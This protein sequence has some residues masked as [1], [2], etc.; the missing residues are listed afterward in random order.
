[1]PISISVDAPTSAEIAALQAA[2]NGLA[3]NSV[4]PGPTPTPTPTPTPVDYFPADPGSAP[5]PSPD[6]SSSQILNGAVSGAPYLRSKNGAIYSW[7]LNASGTPVALPA[8][9][10]APTFVGYQLNIN[11]SP[12]TEATSPPIPQPISQMLTRNGGVYFA[13]QNGQGYG[14]APNDLTNGWS[15]TALPAEN[16]GGT[17]ALPAML[18]DP[19][20]STPAPGSTGVVHLVGPSQA[21]VAGGFVTLAAAVAGAKPGDTLQLDVG[22]VFEESVEITIPLEINGQGTVANPGTVTASFS[23]GA[24][25][26]GSTF[27][28]YA[29]GK[30]GLVPSVDCIF[31]GLEVR[32]FGLTDASAQGTAGIRPTGTAGCTVTIDNCYVHD[33]E[34]GLSS[35]ASL[36]D[37]VITDSLFENCGLGDG[38]THNIYVGT[39]NAVHVSLSGVTSIMPTA[40]P[41]TSGSFPRATG[42]AYGG[43]AFQT[44]GRALSISGTNYFAAADGQPISIPDGTTE[45]FTIA[46]GTTIVKG[47]TDSNH[48]VFTYA[49]SA[50]VPNGAAGGTFSGTIS[51][52]CPSPFVDVGQGT[53]NFSGATFVG[54]KPTNAG[55][56]TATGL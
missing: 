38:F 20:P 54:T 27:T 25:V 18:A 7:A 33:C 8:P 5:F 17:P 36:E 42:S 34:D 2:A 6:N 32:G 45:P 11:G 14:F 15:I 56:G 41:M 35:G 12:I 43:L 22:A 23:G 40:T 37:W 28:T 13:T 51:A 29:L 50:T 19:V 4:S 24:I 44:R 49:V 39:N 46:A 53:V 48:D 47:T 26:D 55:A 1:M 21:A 3:G 9:A 52:S 16:T 10:N 30:G 31:K